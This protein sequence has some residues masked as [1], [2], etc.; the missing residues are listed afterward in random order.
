M[1]AEELGHY[2]KTSRTSPDSWL[3]RIEGL[4]EGHGGHVVGHGFGRNGA[5]AREA[6]MFRFEL[7]GEQY[8][9]IWP[10]LP[11][12][13]SKLAARIQA[14]TLMYHDVKQRIV[15]AAVLGNRAAFFQYL[16]LPNGYTA[17]EVADQDLL[18]AWSGLRR[19]LLTEVTDDVIDGEY[20]NDR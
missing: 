3:M 12:E 19:P 4:I 20:R 15:S 17:S 6:Y 5:Q 11:T 7:D 9:I 2:Y 14:V 16:M 10:V 18:A 1:L 8:K 13:Q